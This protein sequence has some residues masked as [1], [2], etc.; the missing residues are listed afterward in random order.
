MEIRLIIFLAASFFLT[1]ES[2]F[3]FVVKIPAVTAPEANSIIGKIV[4]KAAGGQTLC[5]RGIN[6]QDLPSLSDFSPYLKQAVVASED[7]RFDWHLGTDPL[8]IANAIISRGKRGGSTIT[9]QVARDIFQIR[10]GGDK[11][12]GDK[13]K[14]LLYAHIIELFYSKD[15]ILNTYLNRVNLGHLET[16]NIGFEAASQSYFGK[17]AI[18]LNIQESAS[19]VSI[20]PGPNKLR[21]YGDSASRENE[22]GE[23]ISNAARVSK[24]RN[25]II[26]K[27]ASIGFIN[28]DE[29]FAAQGSALNI[30]N[31]I[32]SPSQ[33]SKA[34][35]PDFCNYIIQ[36]ELP[37]HFSK[38]RTAT[39]GLIVETTLDI[40]TQQK[41]EKALNQSID[42][43]G[44]NFGYS[45]GAILSLKLNSGEIV[46]MVGGTGGINRTL[47]Y[48]QPG[49]T[50]KIFNYIAALE[51]RIPLSRKFSC[52]SLT[53]GITYKSCERSNG[54]K[55][56][57][58]SDGLISSENPISL[59]L[60]QKIGLKK[61]VKIADNLG[62]KF[63]DRVLPKDREKLESKLQDISKE[64]ER[65][66]TELESK[67]KGV[68]LLKQ[69]RDKL[70][71]EYNTI[72]TKEIKSLSTPYTEFDEKVLSPGLVL[73]ETEVRLFDITP[74]YAMIGNH[75]VRNK[76]HGIRKIRDAHKCNDLQN[77]D[78]CKVLYDS[79]SKT[80]NPN[81]SKQKIS[82]NIASQLDDTLR[83]AVKRGTGKLA[84][85]EGSQ[86]AGKTGTTNGG[87]DMWFIGYNSN[88]CLATGVWLGNDKPIKTK[89]DSRLSAELWRKYMQNLPRQNNCE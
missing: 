72:I 58:L 81:S 34:V 60:A 69:E 25:L 19:L 6:H 26:E 68:K 87:V 1:M 38:T 61:I 10:T 74:V 71:Q 44:E 45:Q 52:N 85:F 28:N 46:S 53:W 89:G 77:T 40:E 23:D 24:G 20:L 78:T 55:E 73:G 4:V 15:E 47:S 50:F 32:V 35:L 67:L 36:A 65:K 48:R 63:Q 86:T 70:E 18:F 41:A 13:A 49:S 14:E 54:A 8:G 39:G 79:M 76:S 80:Q 88:Q 3:H 64:Y 31:N 29:K 2:C 37:E 43:S 33:N 27:M 9:H 42:R 56:I 12:I 59:R 17:S 5:Q 21:Y 22:K 82:S 51:E 83:E 30:F 57:S 11:D 7:S 66:N 62:I 84:D 16:I 75:G